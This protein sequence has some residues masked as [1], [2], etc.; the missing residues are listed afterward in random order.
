[1]KVPFTITTNNITLFHK[2]KM[3]NIPQT[4]RK[5]IELKE[6]LLSG[7]HDID[8]IESIV[9]V[10]DMVERASKGDIKVFG[11]DVYYK[12]KVIRN[13]L[14]ERLVSMLDKGYDISPW[15]SFMENVM[16][17]PSE[18]SR[19]RLFD[20]L[21][22]NNS[23]FTEDGH[24][25]AFKRVASDFKDLYT[26]TMDNSPG[27]I[28]EMDR[29]KVDANNNVTCSHGLHVAAS[30]YLNSYAS[31]HDNK[32][33]VCKVNPRDVVAVP[34]DYNE[35]KMRVCRYEVLSEVEVGQ[36]NDIE[37]QEVY[38]ENKEEEPLDLDDT[39]DIVALGEE[40]EDDDLSELVIMSIKDC[41]NID[42]YKINVDRFGDDSNMSVLF[43]FAN[44][45]EWKKYGE[46]LITD[47]KAYKDVIGIDI[48]DLDN[49]I[50][51]IRFEA[52]ITD[53]DMFIN[54]ETNEIDEGGLDS[55]DEN[56]FKDSLKYISKYCDE[57]EEKGMTFLASNGASYTDKE[58][59]EG[60]AKFGSITKWANS[61]GIP[62]STAQGWVKKITN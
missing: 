59:L 34:P 17:N 21:E 48:F 39:V 2:G 52:Y 35:T 4:Y 11:M 9:N 18:D 24:F 3:F 29:E 43:V 62:R 50:E 45:N 23:P 57:D 58:I 61:E 14:T 5:F 33:I 46:N 10:R 36:I 27:K 49:S 1:M 32:T 13:T 16:Q 37:T 56:L 47:F 44:V 51:E 25:L 12:N 26:H 30:I 40:K 6:H 41:I 28:V 31:A 20:F 53:I 42:N 15:I 22:K 38:F 8:F 54:I 55:N 19:N 60:V 7:I